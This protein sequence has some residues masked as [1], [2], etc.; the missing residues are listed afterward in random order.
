VRSSTDEQGA[1]ATRPRWRVRA[2]QVF[3]V[4]VLAAQVGLVLRAY[5]DPHKFFGYQPFNESDTWQAELWRVTADG[6]RVP[7]VEGRWSGYDWDDLVGV[8]RLTGPD[9]LRHASAGAAA[10]VDFLDEALDW[11]ADHTPAD[12]ETRYLEAEVTWY[13]NTRGPFRTVLRS[14]VREEAG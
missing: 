3:V 10:T 7:V 9:R 13:H 2:A 6:E 12:T 8:P 5:H 14:D 11:V 4:V 1:R